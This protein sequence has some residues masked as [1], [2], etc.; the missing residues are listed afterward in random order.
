M[1]TDNFFFATLL[2]FFTGVFAS[3]SAQAQATIDQNRALAGNVT[4]GDAPGFPVTLSVP[5]SYK[6]TGNLV[7]PAGVSGIVMSASGI[8]LD[9]NG[10]NVSGPGACVRNEGSFAVTCSGISG[11]TW[12]IE[13]QGGGNTARNGS[14]RGF[15]AGLRYA[16]ADQL[17][18]IL[19]EH[20]LA[21]GV[22]SAGFDGA[23]TL[24]RG[25]RSQLNG[26]D[27]FVVSAALIQNSTAASNGSNGITG[28][29]IVVYDTV[30]VNNKQ[31]GFT[32]N[33]V[34]VGRTMA[35]AN[36]GGDYVS[37]FSSGNNVKGSSSIP[38]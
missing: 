15:F 13:S 7:V 35:E 28:T 30:S 9:L 31:A 17:E 37:T 22:L 38:F 24:I 34:V 11:N 5:G 33:N 25:L 19:T 16:G 6:L 1:K 20:N 29:R 36:K 27:G 8:T 10:F 4:P 12:G 3:A 23:R 2:V 26:G 18:N 14:V 21:A 32:G